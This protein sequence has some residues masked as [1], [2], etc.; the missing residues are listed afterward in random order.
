V[1]PALAALAWRPL[2]AIDGSIA[3]RNSEIAVLQR[4]GM[5][6]PLPMPA[7]EN[8]AVYVDHA[9][10]AAGQEVSTKA[11]TATASMSSRTARPR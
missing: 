4:V 2:R 7:I 11:T 5:L 6:R 8:L 9:R 1:A 3:H 10:V